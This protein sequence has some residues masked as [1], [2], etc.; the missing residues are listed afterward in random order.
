MKLNEKIIELRKQNTWSQEDFAEKLN[1]SAQ[2][3]SKWELDETI[4]DT[5]CLDKISNI[6]GISVNDLLDEN[7]NPIK[8][9]SNYTTANNNNNNIP[10]NNSNNRSFKIII[11]VI[12]LILVLIGIGVIVAN[13]IVNKKMNQIEP[14]SNPK[15]ITGMFKEYSLSDLF[16]IIFG[17][18]SDFDVD[19]FNGEFKTLYFGNTSEF[20]MGNF[21]DAV[22]KS[23]EENP[24][25]IITVSYNGTETNDANILRNMKK[26]FNT[27]KTYEINYEYD[28]NGLINKANIEI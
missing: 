21:I 1:V 2:T 22:I 12:I 20:F 4:P 18:I 7:I 24:E 26:Q 15:S 6:F 16:N 17:K 14:N 25:H 13:K 23:N 11:L 8:E 19:S 28:E 5:E 10:S 9:K 3:V 27:N